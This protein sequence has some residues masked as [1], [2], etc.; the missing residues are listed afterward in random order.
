MRKVL[1]LTSGALRASARLLLLALSVTTLGPVLHGVHDTDCDPV[2]VLH[3]ESQH[4]FAAPATGEDDATGGD[5]CVACHF[6]RTSRGPVSWEPSGL[7]TLRS[8]G[9]LFH[10]DGQIVAAPSTSPQPSRAPPSLA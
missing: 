6:L 10:S 1:G 8:G 7:H 4:R 3:D 9:L 2:V 5:H